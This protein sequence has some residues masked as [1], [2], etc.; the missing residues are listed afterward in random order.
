LID[1]GSSVT[2]HIMNEFNHLIRFAS[3][4]DLEDISFLS[5]IALNTWGI[6]TEPVLEEQINNF[7][8]SQINCQLVLIAEMQNKIIGYSAFIDSRLSDKIEENRL[9]ITNTVIHPD[10]RRKGI[11]EKIKRKIISICRERN[12]KRITTN[13]HASNIAIINLSKKLGFKEY[14]EPS[15]DDSCKN[16]IFM[17][18]WL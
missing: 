16:D 17:E 1:P 14:I 6:I 12:V 5:N 10:F 13:H 3:R 18:L 2:V 9:H 4:K 11:A 7:Y 15:V 8:I